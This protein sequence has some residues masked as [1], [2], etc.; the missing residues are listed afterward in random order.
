MSVNQRLGTAAESGFAI[1]IAIMTAFHFIQPE[2][3]PLERFGSEYVLGRLGWMMNVAFV[4]FGS[5]L[6]AFA[7]ALACALR[8]AARSRVGQVLFGFTALGI[9]GSGL[10]SA[11][12]N[13][14][15]E[16]W[17]GIGHAIAGLVAFL[18]MLPAMVIV[19]WR[20]RRANALAG[21]YRVLRLL[22]WVNV[23]LFLAS[24]FLFEPLGLAGLGQRIFLIGMFAWLLIAA[25][26]IRSGKFDANLL[27]SRSAV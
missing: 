27:E 13:G 1:F 14:R 3:N 12:P 8:P 17:H 9:L 20:L 25:E 24:L 5:G 22:S 18:S 26:G 7:L 21:G 11:D 10:F 6:A 23:V 19:S 15:A 16:S 4:S 2:L